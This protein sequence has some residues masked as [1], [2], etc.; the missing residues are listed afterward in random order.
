M[1]VRMPDGTIVTGV[2]EGITQTELLARYSKYTPTQ[3]VEPERPSL[4]SPM[5]EEMGA[6]IMA[7]PRAT[8]P[9]PLAPVAPLV[10]PNGSLNAQDYLAAVAKRK[11]ENPDR[12]VSDVVVDSG[13]TLLKSAIGLP[14][15]FVGL[16]DIPTMGRVGKFLEDQGYKPKEAKAILDTYLSE[17]QQAA[18]RKVSEAKGFGPTLLAGLQNPSVI[19]SSA[20]ESLPQMVGGAGAARGLMKAA[21]ALAPWLAGALGEG[22]LGAGSAAEQMRQ[23]SPTGVLT[24]KQS[25]A[26]VGSGAGTAAFGAVAGRLANKL[27]LDDVETMLATGSANGRSKSIGDFAKR[28]GA[29]G[30]SEGVFEELPQSAQEQMWMNYATDKPLMEGVAEASAMGLLTGAAMGMAG[31]GA[32]QLLGRREKAAP[33]PA[34]RPPAGLEALVKP[35]RIEPTFQPENLPAAPATEQPQGI[36][37]LQ[38]KA[39]EPAAP[40]EA[41]AAAPTAPAEET[42]VDR[43]A[44]LQELEAILGT[45]PAEKPVTAP[46]VKPAE[47]QVPAAEVAE[48]PAFWQGTPVKVLGKPFEEKGVSYVRV[49]FPNAAGTFTGEG[50]TEDFV[51]AAEVTTQAVAPEV[52]PTPPAQPP[53]A[54]KLTT[55]AEIDARVK[56]LMLESIKDKTPNPARDAE[57]DQLM[58]QKKAMIPTSGLAVKEKDLRGNDNISEA[59]DFANTSDE[60]FFNTATN[61]LATKMFDGT[62]VKHYAGDRSTDGVA[63]LQ[64][65]TT[66]EEVQDAVNKGKM[67]VTV[68]EGSDAVK[69]VT[70]N[71]DMLKRADEIARQ[72]QIG[73]Y[74]PQPT[75]EKAIAAIDKIKT[76]KV[77]DASSVGWMKGSGIVTQEP[78]KKP[79]FTRMGDRFAKALVDAH[80]KLT[81]EQKVSRSE[82]DRIIRE[83]L[84]KAK[85]ATE[86][87]RAKAVAQKEAPV[88]T[89]EVAKADQDFDDAL[90]DLSMILTKGV[91]KNMMPE[92]EQALL[93]VLTRLMD[94]AFRKG[95]YKFKEAAKFVMDTIRDKLGKDAAD[96]IT[97]DHLQGAYIGMAG[98]YQDQGASSKKDVVA[99]ESLDEL[100]EAAPE[101]ELFTLSNP[102]QK[103]EVAQAIAEHFAEGDDF[104]G[105]VAARK[106]ISEK[107]GIEIRPGS[108]S[109]KQADETIEA[110]I[111]LAARD[112]V[113]AGRKDKLTVDQIYDKL[114][115]LYERQPNL[116]VRSS[117]SVANQAYSTPAPLAYVASE[118][119]GITN[120]TTVYEPTAGNGMLLIAANPSNVVANEL[121]QD[122]FDMLKRIMDGAEVV[123]KNAIN[124]QPDLV[125]VVIA[126]PPFGAIGEEVE[127]GGKKTREIDHAIS[128]TALSRM[129]SDGKAVLIVGGVNETT[130][131]ARREGYR[132]KAK[133][134]FYYNLYQ[135]YNVVDHFTV[136]GN[137][138]A[139]QGASYPVDVIVID[140]KG[141]SQRNLPAA[142]L[143]Q[144]IKSYDQLKEKLNDRMVSGENRGTSRTDRGV[145]E[146]GTAGRENVD[147]GAGVQGNG[148]GTAGRGTTEGGGTSVQGNEPATGGRREPAG[149]RAGNAQPG[150]ENATERGGQQPVAGTSE[151]A[152]RGERAAE[153]RGPAKLGGVSVVS[154][155]RVGSGLTNRAGQEQ[156][157]EGQV[158]YAPFSN[159]N[160]VG[161][162]VPKAMAEAIN[163][164]L[165]TLEAAVGSIDEYVATALEMDPE[166]VRELFSA[167][168]V[169][170]L[171]LSIRNAEA[172]KGFI[173][174]DQTGVGK[175]RVVAAMIRY[176]LVN[177]KVPIF[178]TEKPNLYSDMIRD[179]DDI[180]M[181][182]ELGLDTA[183]PKILI[184]NNDEKIPY[185][186]LRDVNGEIVENNLTLK[187]PQKD[188]KLDAVFKRM[189]DSE[190]L[191]DYKVIFTTYNQLQTVKGKDTERRRL[192]KQ[193]G[194]GNYMIFD[195]SHNAGGAG[196]TQART[197]EQREK[198]QEGQSLATGRAAFVRNLVQNAYGTFFSSAT[199]AKKPDVMDLYSS[200][201]M[202]LAVKNLNELADA[203]KN[204]GIP[205]QQTVANM[206]A[207]AGQYI[208]R[209]RTF[210][211]VSY[212]TTETKVDKQTAENMASSMRDILAFSRAKEVAVKDLK[213]QLDKRGAAIAGGPAEKTQVASANF[214][215]IMHNLIDQ[216]LL[217]LKVQSSIDHAIERLKAGEKVVMTVSNTM[218]SFLKDYADEMGLVAGDKV[219]LSFKDMY[220][221][222]LEKQ[223]VIKIKSPG[224]R[225]D[226]Y[227]LTD[228]DLGPGLVQQF[229]DVKAFIEGAGFGSAPISPI[230]YLHAELNKAGYKTEEITGRTVTVNY[231][232]G[233]P[234]LASRN[235]SIAKRV[236]AVKNF[237][238]G[239]S[240]VMILNQAGSTGLSLHASSKFDDKRK[241]HMIIIQ[242]EKN[243]DTHMQMLGRVHRTGQVIPPA[244]SQMMADIPA[245]MRPAAVLLKKM[246]SLNA[247]TTGSRKSAVSA[248]GAVDFMNDYGGQVVTEFLRDN[249]EVYQALGGKKV[250]DLSDDPSEASEEDIR[251]VTGYIPILP[252]KQQE[253]IYKDLVERYKDL[254]EREDSMGTNKL[255]SKAV[256][257]DAKTIESKQITEDKQNESG[258]QS[259]FAKP[260]M[261]ERVDVKRTVKPYSQDDVKEQIKDNLKG[262]STVQASNQMLTA[263]RER[264]ANFGKEQVSAMESAKEPDPVKIENF[265]SQLNAQFNH[266]KTVGQTFPVGTPVSIKNTNGVFVYGVVTNIEAKGKTKNPV[267]GSDLK[268]TLALANGDAKSITLTFSQIGSAYTLK[269]EDEV[270]WFNQ[271]TERYDRIPLM[272]LFDKGATVRREKRWMVTGNI[273]AGYAAVNNMGQIM[274]YT[275]DD[276]TTAQGV[277]M[278]RTFD[279]EK[280]QK[281]APVKLNNAEAVMAFFDKFGPR[282]IVGTPDNVLKIIFSGGTQYKFTTSSA[283]REG[284]TFFLDK[285]LTNLTGDFYKSG[286]TMTA[287]VYGQNDVREAV[288]YLLSDRGESL[289]ALTN[290]DE[291]RAAFQPPLANIEP[292]QNQKVLNPY[293]A[294]DVDREDLIRRFQSARQSRAA[295]V[296]KFIKGE[297]GLTEQAKITELDEVA[298]GLKAA[299]AKEKPERRSAGN[300]FADATKQWDEGNLSDAVYEVI[301][302]VHSKYPFVLEGLKLSVRKQP[303]ALSAAGQFSPAERFVYLYKGTT[304]VE[305]PSTIRHELVHSLEQM[306]SEEATVAVIEEWHKQLERKIK[307]DKTARGKAFFDKL[308]AFY[309]H[310]TLETYEI[311]MDALPS[312]DYYQ[313]MNPSEYWAVNAESLM[314]RK[315]GS[316]WDRF[317]L[318]AKRL[319]ESVK[320]L[321]GFDNKSAVHKAFNEVMSGKEKR[322]GNA[323]LVNYVTSEKVLLNN[324][325]TRLNYRGKEAPLSTWTSPE[326]NTISDWQRRLQDK[327]VDTKKV[328]ESIRREMGEIP[329]IHDPRLMETL[330][331]GRVREQKDAMVKAHVIP[332]LEEMIKFKISREE[333]DTYLHNRH[334]ETRNRIN[335]ERGGM[336]D[337]GSGIFTEDAQ[338][339]LSELEKNP[340]HLAKLQK[341]ADRVDTIIKDT[342]DHL[343]ETGQETKEVIESWREN[344]PDYV[345]LKRDED[346]LDFVS[347]GTGLGQGFASKGAFSKA[348]AGSLKTVD[349]I[350]GNVILQA[351][352][353]I[354]RGEKA[355]VG[356]AM[357]G[358]AIIAPNPEFWLPISPDAIKSTKKLE[359]ELISLGLTKEDRD[360]IMME[361][362]SAT[363]DKQTG[364]LVYKINP[365][366]RNSKN[367]FPI[368]I[369]GKDRYIIF[370]AGDPVAMHMVTALKNLDANSV[371]E[372]LS[373]LAE[374]TRQMASMNTQ[375]NLVFGMWNFA[376]DVGEAGVN[377]SN[378]PIADKRKEVVANSV[379]AV[380]AIY[381]S[382]RGKEATT[383]EMKRWMEWYKLFADVGGQVGYSEQFRK[384]KEGDDILAREMKRLENKGI[385]K[386]L[387]I[388]LRWMSDFNDSAENAVRL[389]AFRTAVENG[390]S[391]MQAARL[392]K[393]ITV[394]F[395]RKGSWTSNLNAFWAFFNARVQGQYR[396]Y[397]TLTELNDKGERTLSK[398]GMKIIKGGMLF[399]VLQAFALMGGGFEDDDIPD[400][401]K[402]KN[403]IIPIFGTKK[404]LSFPMPPGFAA[405]PAIG[406]VLGEYAFSGFEHTGKRLSQI[407]GI[408]FDTL[409]P[410]GS[411]DFAQ[412]IAPTIFDPIVGV[413]STNRDAFGRPIHREDRP[414]Q[415]SPGWTRSRENA[416]FLGKA[417]AY[418]INY[419]SGGGEH[420]IGKFS[421]TGDDIDYLAGQY[422]GGAAREVIRAGRFVGALFGDE[423]IPSYKVP[424]VGKAYGEIGTPVAITDQFYQH[425]NELAKLE[426]EIK[427]MKQDH[428]STN[429]YKRDNPETKLISVANNLE[430]EISKL[431]KSKKELLEKEQTDAI[432]ARIKRIDEQKARMMKNFNDRFRAAEK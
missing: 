263:L 265:K 238:N 148:P 248:E 224:G 184:T 76:K 14:E 133:R 206:L 143:P 223:R 159:A 285:D 257:L 371:S 344:M 35:E 17:A 215:S 234:L 375:Y 343:I 349:N 425:V 282:S 51:P 100:N 21:P 164:A 254:I 287:T 404:Y 30:V 90:A 28:A 370:N 92:Q 373:I 87:E 1:D 77:A 420:G 313:Y 178:V 369:N 354:V 334:A 360:N 155:E 259:V 423:P 276:G 231:S 114:V 409:N 73:K 105:I 63:N 147:L 199:Y 142:D 359:A 107:F 331:Y 227:R 80:G 310:P 116:N 426:N 111:V 294:S 326:I 432:K 162:L 158:G 171:A 411:S 68:Q 112:I 281:N 38:P 237:N 65:V 383:P 172:G 229:N 138:Y 196:E 335:A 290:K 214:G 145:G 139:K 117:T 341:L 79:Q 22:I 13:V 353:A 299:I 59:S 15:A 123:N 358:L 273:L 56:Q 127:V 397:E 85:T 189:Q 342:Q 312:Y 295:I 66:P 106:F 202:K 99:V 414:S 233:K 293:M 130:E 44:M 301:R 311:A 288:K 136:A 25:L 83:S 119:A 194:A 61:E 346:E 86:K 43:D 357:Y 266:A 34:E 348:S 8:K 140:G 74:S 239:T 300:F 379:P 157:T 324:Q 350:I 169:D 122:R 209:E 315:L 417:I 393:E 179:L 405:L 250:I 187:A 182:S 19:A 216:M 50:S 225:V 384:N 71:A 307:S 115:D 279:F 286:P 39:P 55:E 167:E 84:E 219:D 94:A 5:G 128:Y 134:E 97:L 11:E 2:P 89:P 258:S 365:A 362:K 70:T 185:T 261:M 163:N 18:N 361:P 363:F 329:D 213:K 366:L 351:E 298:N 236:Q 113:E 204:G 268:M 364:K 153:E 430:N 96:M 98:K 146:A 260:A 208:R 391:E 4:G 192:I 78:G 284:G 57:I 271:E 308:M 382:L 177:G 132:S 338:K 392:A 120:K 52:K 339:Y 54:P 421:P 377:L 110:G 328:V 272:E 296:R 137:M 333:L 277:L 166:T 289:V 422:A 305:D 124:F 141:Q 20:V 40:V 62:P 190:S 205:M 247:N 240:D 304:G 9:A 109:A 191:G 322:I 235:S 406:R 267:A 291:A 108:E 32:S 201:D 251:K 302:D 23:E 41:P 401:I 181:T 330:Y 429:E 64:P 6:S 356:R 280:E 332:L 419:I 376:R 264:T 93:P 226:E 210:A 131:D 33:P 198:A 24:P 241:R 151:T 58:A 82:D 297:A 252:I 69:P 323:A 53:A 249:P 49:K 318:G 161:T 380:R 355:R 372:G 410:L 378:T 193:F 327:H 428:V 244:Y 387:D 121:N 60:A 253:E 431:N 407:T 176:A 388:S 29:S 125:E 303:G 47:A 168:Q 418:G 396:N 408:V 212:D 314:A 415:P 319:Y 321:F 278:P 283:K 374:A 7:A 37:A 403:L 320:N 424:L 381:R 340:E 165:A 175:G 154:G 126:N 325:N 347:V 103:F 180:G 150:S 173:I 412:T 12:S 400:Y 427:R 274:T 256:D 183:N 269:Q 174:G 306:M 48:Q 243:I 95:Y 385:R 245:E 275:K 144:V 221:R 270:P 156:E 230:D 149:G 336:A 262:L 416:S 217:S 228:A 389:S 207:Q 170:A 45:K 337:G 220:L 197:K 352:K 72:N 91:R 316:G 160:S 88:K 118:L 104:P 242:P 368:R 246:A 46:E 186:L 232:T 27:G 200:T 75:A 102:E 195:E 16:A 31:T 203:I 10:Q 402:N 211:G 135:D 255:E 317:V 36:A 218:G 394:N 26:A 386:G 81:E 395:D 367:V 129:Q 222:Y 188:A 309:D 152:K 292:D 390:M 413:L 3:P 42:S 101:E 345:P 398:L 67:F 399:G